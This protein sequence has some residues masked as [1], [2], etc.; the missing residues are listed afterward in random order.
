VASGERAFRRSL[1]NFHENVAVVARLCQYGC[2]TI[3]TLFRETGMS[4]SA[5]IQ[6]EFAPGSYG[7]TIDGEVTAT[8]FQQSYAMQVSAG[9]VMIITFTGAGPMRGGVTAPAGQSGDGPYYGTGN[10]Y[11][12]PVNGVYIVYCGANTMAG[13]PWTGGFTL[14]VLVSNP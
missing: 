8:V 13:A 5:P 9:Q 6:I 2:S 10:T 12:A 3:E 1:H 11:T 4:G 14:A 7:T